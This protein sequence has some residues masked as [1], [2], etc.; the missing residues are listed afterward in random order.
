MLTRSELLSLA[1]ELKGLADSDISPLKDGR[2]GIVHE[3]GNGNKTTIPFNKVAEG[4]GYF[5]TIKDAAIFFETTDGKFTP[6]SKGSLDF[7]AIKNYINQGSWAY[8]DSEI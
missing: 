3:D 7:R 4:Y 5:V 2:I 1:A 8:I 6:V